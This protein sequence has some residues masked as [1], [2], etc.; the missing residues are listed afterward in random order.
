LSASESHRVDGGSAFLLSIQCCVIHNTG[1]FTPCKT[2]YLI[3]AVTG[4][5][6]LWLV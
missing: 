6:L 1:N 4:Y 2:L 5:V 3:T